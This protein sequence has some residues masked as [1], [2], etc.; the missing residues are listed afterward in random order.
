MQQGV[1]SRLLAG[2]P[3]GAPALPRPALQTPNPLGK[4]ALTFRAWR[5]FRDGALPLG[6][7]PPLE[8]PP[9]RPAVPVLVPPRDIPSMDRSPLP[10]A[11]YMLHNLAHVRVGR[12]PSA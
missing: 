7:A 5:A 1:D 8:G 10:K 9:A 12:G 3:T 2:G 6:A 4:A 11:V